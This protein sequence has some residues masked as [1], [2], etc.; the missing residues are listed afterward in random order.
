M[1][2]HWLAAPLLCCAC[3]AQAQAPIAPAIA[4]AM[5]LADD[6][7]LQSWSQ[8]FAQ[9]VDHRLE[10]PPEVQQAY[11]TRLQQT[12]MEAQIDDT[13]AQAFVLVDRS[14]Q[15]QAAFVILR[16]PAGA[17]HWLG[18][19]AVSTGRVG[20]YEHFVTPLGV[21]AHTLTNPDFRA[22]G[23][24][25]QNKIRGYGLKGLRV[26]DFGWQTAV[27]G[28]GEGGKSLMRLQMHATDP[29]TLEGRVGTVQSEG[30]VRI[31]TTLNRFLDQHG[32][33]D[34]EYEE[35]LAEGQKLWI[36][37]PGRALMP[38]TG[39]YLVVVDSGA[40]ERPVW[41]PLPVT[42]RPVKPARKVPAK[43]PQ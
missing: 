23:T 7:A 31:P 19:T 18:A 16:T 6:A 30:C 28:W 17:W 9:E 11:I 41:S 35:A 4:R 22:E 43:N 8:H 32:V 37:P 36:I 25:N 33:L 40:T 24:Y 21:F 29:A 39:N 15:V 27:R 38:W 1:S 3:A 13:S 34:A 12:L 10:V 42:A 20:Q 5:G 14:P 2:R 26:F